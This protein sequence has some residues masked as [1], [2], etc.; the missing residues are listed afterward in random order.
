M[1]LKSDLI[2]FKQLNSKKCNEIRHKFDL[3]DDSMIPVDT[4]YRIA[5]SYGIK[6]KIISSADFNIEEENELPSDL[7]N[8]I[9]L[10]THV[11]LLH[12]EHYYLAINNMKVCQKCNRKYFG[13]DHSCELKKCPKCG[14]EYLLNHK[15]NE[16]RASYNRRYISKYKGIPL[17]EPEMKHDFNDIISYD[18]ETYPNENGIFIASHLACYNNL[19]GYHVFISDSNEDCTSKFIDFLIKIRDSFSSYEKV[20]LSAYNG[21]SFDSY[22]IINGLIKK[23]IQLD[24]Y[25]I[26]AGKNLRCKF[27]DKYTIFDLNRHLVGSLRANLISFNVET[28]KGDFNYNKINRHD[29]MDEK[30]QQDL[31]DYLYS[32]VIGLHQLTKIYASEMHQMTQLDVF[33]YVSAPSLGYRYLYS[34][35]NYMNHDPN[36]E[37]MQNREFLPMKPLGDEIRINDPVLIANFQSGAFK[38]D[39]EIEDLCAQASY[40]GRTYVTQRDYESSQFNLEKLLEYEKKH[41]IFAKMALKTGSDKKEFLKSKEYLNFIN[42]MG[43]K[44]S[45][46]NDFVYC[47]DITSLYPS[48]MNM[49]YF[50]SGNAFKINTVEEYN[51]KYLGIY[52]CT[53]E[54]KKK[55]LMHPFPQRI[56]EKLV[57]TLN[58]HTGIYT[59]VDIETMLS[60][61]YEIT[62][63]SGVYFKE[64]L[65]PFKPYVQTFFKI[66]DQCDKAGLKNDPKRALSKLMMNSVYG[67]CLEKPHYEKSEFITNSKQYFDILKDNEITK[68]VPF[69]DRI[70]VTY[71]PKRIED[72]NQMITKSKIF[73]AFI[74][75]YSRSIMYHFFEKFDL[76]YNQNENMLYSDTDS[77]FIRMTPE[78]MKIFKELEDP[79]LKYES[80][81]G[82]PGNDLDLNGKILKMV[83]IKAKLYSYIYID[84]E[85]KIFIKNKCAGLSDKVITL[86][87]F[88]AMSNGSSY[89]QNIDFIFQKINISVSKDHKEKDV[90]PFSIMKHDK[91]SKR[92]TKVVNQSGY[93]ISRIHIDKGRPSF[94]HGFICSMIDPMEA[95]LQYNKYMDIKND[96]SVF[97]LAKDEPKETITYHGKFG[98]TSLKQ[99]KASFEFGYKHRFVTFPLGY[100]KAPSSNYI[101]YRDT[102]FTKMI[103]IIENDYRQ[104][105]R[106]DTG[107]NVGILTGKRNDIMHFNLLIIDLDIKKEQGID[108]VKAFENICNDLK[109]KI[110]TLTVRTGSHGLHLYFKVD[111]LNADFIL[112]SKD[113]FKNI[114]I[115]GLECRGIDLQ[116]TGAQAVC[117]FSVYPRC[118][119]KCS[120]CANGKEECLFEGNIYQIVN[121]VEIQELPTKLAKV[122][123]IRQ[124]NLRDLNKA[125]IDLQLS[126]KK[127]K[128]SIFANLDDSKHRLETALPENMAYDLNKVK[129]IFT[130]TIP[131]SAYNDY[132]SWFSI[133][134]RLVSIG[135]TDSD[136]YEMTHEA[137]YL[138]HSN[139][140][141]NSQMRSIRSRRNYQNF[142]M[143]SLIN[144]MCE[145]TGDKITYNRRKKVFMLSEKILDIYKERGIGDISI[146]DEDFTEA[147]SA[148]KTTK[149]DLSEI[150]D[151]A[152]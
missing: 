116:Y 133:V 62:I 132:G 82:M 72:L 110:N 85:N 105:A 141:F 140:K 40:G 68:M 2:D 50:P 19:F 98:Y 100:I 17:R 103:S 143:K 84:S 81:L 145:V 102:D 22:F 125:N 45:E 117:P 60:L 149:S 31:L 13:I 86:E 106:R 69:N 92:C 146:L 7:S 39:K 20:I 10:N 52:K 76:L 36:F 15:C 75:S 4:L 150:T 90:N 38:Y 71:T 126:D 114:T 139:S 101:S 89:T 24:D 43:L 118:N 124:S 107:Q 27:L 121:D 9:D 70:Y 30:D 18:Y 108:A 23:G 120:N 127:A 104:L 138:K 135:F 47:L 6:I 95:K 79:N 55:D 134:I 53:V 80:N 109:V 65:N 21:S 136:I 123:S 93:D 147:G 144:W 1:N 129:D 25:L 34:V 41:K 48:A 44:H 51:R 91:G 49:G 152:S 113:H 37:L 74:L 111:D 88:I 54:H 130:H 115:A 151:L 66:K 128:D 83:N 12:N 61:G 59:S 33:N 142:T 63:H 87:D 148:N 16:N 46:V 122:C 97:I 3:E 119:K 64:Y 42:E 26:N 58:T 32:D 137:E 73:G 56:G 131:M 11:I 77:F 78:K 96:F 14:R 5:E 57:Y 112:N 35:Q 8:E 94:P 99:M 28:K 67:K 29:L